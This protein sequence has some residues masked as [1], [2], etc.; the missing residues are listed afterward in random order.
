MQ[1]EVEAQ[2]VIPG[3]DDNPVEK[4]RVQIEEADF[5]MADEDNLSY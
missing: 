3:A 5:E 1:Y 4:S 2:L